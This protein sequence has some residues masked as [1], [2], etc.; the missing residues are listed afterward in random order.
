M[1]N[2]VDFGAV[3]DGKALCTE[4]FRQAIAAAK[5]EGD[6]VNVPP[7]TYLTGTIDLRGVSLHLEKGAVIRG[8][9]NPADYPVMPYRHNEMG[10]L[11][12]LIVCLG[13]ENVVLD[14]D[15]VIDF[16][17]SAFYDFSRPRVPERRVPFTPEQ[18]KEC[19]V[20]R[21]WRPT[22]SL[23]FL[24]VDGVAVRDLTLLDAPCWTVTFSGCRNVKA[25]GLTIDTSLNVPN[26]DGIHVSSC[27]G[28]LISQCHI[29]SGDD[30]I[31][32]SGITDW[33]VPCEHI[34]ISD[35]VLRSCSKAIV[36]GYQYSH[37]RNVLVENCVIRESNR[38]L[39]FM[40]NDRGGLVEN[41]RVRNLLIDTRIRAGDWWGNGEA[42]FFMGIKHDGIIPAEQDPHRD[43]PVNF[44]HIF[45]EGVT[46]E[47]ENAMGAVGTGRNYEDVALRDIVV[48]RKPSANLPLKG[49]VFDIAP[50]PENV[51]VPEDCLVYVKDAG[52]FRLENVRALP[53]QGRAQSVIME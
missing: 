46:C 27:D 26:D 40:C 11:R 2:I 21:D 53:Y 18:L 42:I 34:V 3:G 50:A 23:F 17:G 16:N 4:S 13:G 33:A 29:T 37:V 14:G 15:G 48:S 41:V 1:K 22:M 45:V 9:D 10:D 28:V 38:G 7:G 20:E 12:A 52:D 5:A 24:N 47:S 49:R 8:S 51:P 19:T 43:T 31:A 30:C 32:L 36:I 39:C 25:L 35:C 6:W 44:R